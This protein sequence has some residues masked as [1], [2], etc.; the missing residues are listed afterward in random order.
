VAGKSY[1]NRAVTVCQTGIPKIAKYPNLTAH[2][3]E[4]QTS[5]FHQQLQQAWLKVWK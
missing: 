3:F 2:C 4:T 5:V 1:K